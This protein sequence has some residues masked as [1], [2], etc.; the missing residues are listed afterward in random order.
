M[1][2]GKI[3]K[4]SIAV[5]LTS[6]YLNTAIAQLGGEA[7]YKF[8]WNP[9]DA[10]ITGLGGNGIALRDD[11]A[12][13]ALQN[14]ALLNESSHNKCSFNHRFFY[15]GLQ[16]GAFTYAFT[17]KSLPYN[18]H[19]AFQY[20]N[21][22]D[23]TQSDE[24]GNITG[25]FKASDLAFTVG[26]SRTLY[27]NVALGVNL[28]YISS[29]LESY[30]SSG[31]AADI[32]ATYFVPDKNLVFSLVCRNIGTQLT[33][34][35][36]NLEKLPYELQAGISKRLAHLPFRFSIVYTNLQRW[37]VLYDDPARQTDNNLF[38]NEDSERSDFAVFTDNLFRHFVFNG[39]FF[40]GKKENLRLRLGYNH[41]LRKELSVGSYRSLAGFS[42]GLGFK[43]NRFRFDYGMTIYHLVGKAHHLSLS[44]DIDS[45]R[46]K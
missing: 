46:K 2:R 13:L 35:N 42:G 8:L 32:G 3:I 18:F 17:P 40:I 27:E 33:D 1:S 21:Y 11:D 7:V 10:H 44:T 43:I 41:M 4:F 20:A 34:Y 29:R 16:D 38:N 19:A 14:P 6:L 9:P 5:I 23:F 30:S 45:F 39:E 28:K 37:N 15:S 26:A 31:I 24:Y 22:G 12:A 36:D 25:T